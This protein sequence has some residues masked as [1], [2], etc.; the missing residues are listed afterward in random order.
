MTKKTAR[1]G[2]KRV[3]AKRDENT[4][5]GGMVKPEMPVQQ[6]LPMDW[7]SPVTNEGTLGAH[8]S[9]ANRLIES[10]IHHLAH[11]YEVSIN[12]AHVRECYQSKYIPS[13]DEMLEA[14]RAQVLSETSGDEHQKS[15]AINDINETKAKVQRLLSLVIKR[16]NELADAEIALEKAKPDFRDVMRQRYWEAK[17]RCEEAERQWGKSS[18]GYTQYVEEIADVCIRILK[19]LA[20][21]LIDLDSIGW[22]ASR[23]DLGKRRDTLDGTMFEEVIQNL[24]RAASRRWDLARR[25]IREEGRTKGMFFGQWVQAVSREVRSW[26]M[27]TMVSRR[28]VTD[29]S[30]GCSPKDSKLAALKEHRE[31]SKRRWNVV[32]KRSCGDPEALSFP[33]DLAQQTTFTNADALQRV[34]LPLIRWAFQNNSELWQQLSDGKRAMLTG[35]GELDDGKVIKRLARFVTF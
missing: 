19:H 22:L 11:V 16:R 34:L 26:H 32:L 12:P 4:R 17:M 23:A 21:E 10:F 13:H 5:A 33:D 6:H 7:T 25:P 31:R 30:K 1:S 28:I 18:E 2:A 8:P 35:K 14:A 9:T 20:T 15:R 3:Q 24:G 29:Y 27:M